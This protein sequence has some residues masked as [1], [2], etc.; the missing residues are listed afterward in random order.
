M[1]S[2]KLKTENQL[3][4][5]RIQELTNIQATLE[6]C[7]FQKTNAL[8]NII[9]ILN[10]GNTIKA[11]TKDKDEKDVIVFYSFRHGIIKG[12]DVKVYYLD[13]PI[14]NDSFLVKILTEVDEDKI[15]I[16]DIFSNEVSRGH[17]TLA[18][19]TLK[20][21]AEEIE[22][23]ISGWISPVDFDHHDRLIYFYKKNGFEVDY[24]QQA[25]SGRVVCN[26]SDND[27]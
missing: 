8:E 18:V 15:Y 17:G 12:L 19:N 9:T 13:Y 26:I 21:I 14:T 11:I 16:V 6:E 27:D 5:N 24:N 22:L 4:N 1:F 3:L 10:D 2:K 23:K 25:K 7:L 20:K